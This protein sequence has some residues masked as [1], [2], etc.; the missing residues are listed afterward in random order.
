VSPDLEAQI[1]W[2]ESYKHSEKAGEQYYFIIERRDG[3]PI[4][5]VRIYDLREDS[6]CWGSWIL[7][8]DKTRYSA[9]ESAFL[10]YEFGFD[11]L[12]FKK[13][14]YEV[15]K[16]NERVVAFHQK[17]GAVIIGEDEDNL[18]FTISK[19]AVDTSKVKLSALIGVK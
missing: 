2:I 7:N 6:F 18:F 11:V 4:G 15:M 10:V 1:S 8:K 5:T 14:H 3:L 16:G 9:L 12:G 17:M 13:S 19:T